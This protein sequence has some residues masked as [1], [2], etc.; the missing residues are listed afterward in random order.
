[1]GHNIR[2]LRT[3]AILKVKHTAPRIMAPGSL[4]KLFQKKSRFNDRL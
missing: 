2:D 1:M 3:V 4:K